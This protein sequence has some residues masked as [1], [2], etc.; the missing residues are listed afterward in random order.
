MSYVYVPN[1]TFFYGICNTCL[2]YFIFSLFRTKKAGEN[3]ALF[4]P[5][6]DILIPFES[7]LTFFS[8]LLFFLLFCLALRLI[9]RPT[10]QK[11]LPVMRQM[12]HHGTPR[13]C[14]IMICDGFRD[15]PVGR[16]RLCPQ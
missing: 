2:M 1:L 9:G 6:P 14:G 8:L 5:A 13:P 7:L 4:F 12:H 3:C 16:D 11:L 15:G 10:S